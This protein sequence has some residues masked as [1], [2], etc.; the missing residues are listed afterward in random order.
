ME[1]TV[2]HLQPRLQCLADLVPA[3]AKL[4]DVGTDHG[5]LPVWLVQR[6][7]ISHAIASDINEAPLRHARETAA[8]CGVTDRIDFRLCSGLDAVAPHEAD[9][10]VIAGMGAETIASVLSAA[11]WTRVGDCLLLIQPM[12][13]A[14]YLRCWLCDKGYTFTD[15]R[16]VR[17]KDFLYPVFSV[18]GG[19]RRTLSPAEAYGGVLLDADPLYVQYLNQQIRR[20][21][22]RL[23]G[24][25]TARSD[26]ASEMEKWSA[27]RSALV[28]KREELQ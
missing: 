25:S 26:N 23:E 8:R 3:G 21:E 28:K 18:R 15:E 11:P 10:V 4:V 2:L 14:E 27:L 7:H 1:H 17:D 24:L 9:T 12:T 22:T 19:T 5:Y 20:L 6:G 13:K 16:L